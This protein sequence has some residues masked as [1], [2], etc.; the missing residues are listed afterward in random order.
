MKITIEEIEQTISTE[1]SKLV[2]QFGDIMKNGTND[3]DNFITINE[4][5]KHWGD[6]R[7]ATD[8]I[9]TDMVSQMLST[10]DE[11]E[12]VKKKEMSIESKE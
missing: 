12:I 11:R 8:K 5:E 7:Q 9:Y 10:I 2:K 1:L 3:T 6:L 4:I